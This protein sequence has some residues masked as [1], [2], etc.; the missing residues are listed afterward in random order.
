MEGHTNRG[1]PTPQTTS[2]TEYLLS[3]LQASTS[4]GPRAGRVVETEV[5]RDKGVGRGLLKEGTSQ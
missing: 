4:V 2:R 3:R 1:S 5:G